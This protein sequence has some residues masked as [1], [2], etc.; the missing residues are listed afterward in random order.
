MSAFTTNLNL[1]LPGGG[2]LGIGGDDE[3]ADVDKLNQNFQKIDTWSGTVDDAV[4]DAAFVQSGT[5]SFSGEGTPTIVTSIT[6]PEPFAAPPDVLVGN[7]NTSSTILAGKAA[8]ITSSG[9]AVRVTATSTFS[10][11]Y[12]ITWIAV[13]KRP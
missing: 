8:S 2:S 5:F 9:C 12:S 1:E 4:T 6:F 13:G 10:S 3:A 11:S 7:E